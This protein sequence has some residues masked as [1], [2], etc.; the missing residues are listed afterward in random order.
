M[1]R[2]IKLVR[3]SIKVH[4]AGTFLA[5]SLIVGL[6][7][8]DTGAAR[9]STLVSIDLNTSDDGLLTLDTETGLEWL[10]LTQ[11]DLGMSF[12]QMSAQLDP[13]GTFEGFRY[14]TEGE[15][16]T[17][18]NN[19][20]IDAAVTGEENFAPVT[21][22]QKLLGIT[23]IAFGQLNDSFGMTSTALGIPPCSRPCRRSIFVRRF[24]SGEHNGKALVALN[25]RTLDLAGQNMAHWLIRLS[26]S[27]DIYGGIYF[28]IR[29]RLIR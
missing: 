2:I 28:P 13:G 17:L 8:I 25:T 19:A 7:V 4:L 20:D 14:A 15:V 12:N 18:V 1:S 9:A 27:A 22:F 23:D 6:L 10:D 29:R 24:L 11:T 3:G 5:V 21:N 16:L 26:S